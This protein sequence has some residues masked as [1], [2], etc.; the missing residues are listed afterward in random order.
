MFLHGFYGNFSDTSEKRSTK[1]LLRGYHVY[2]EPWEATVGQ[3]V[4]NENLGMPQTG[5]RVCY[6]SKERNDYRTLTAVERCRVFA[7]Y[8]QGDRPSVA[9]SCLTRAISRSN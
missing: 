5:T 2:P 6:G 7:R 8:S 4:V 1:G 3:E 9:G